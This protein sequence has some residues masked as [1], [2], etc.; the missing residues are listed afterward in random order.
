MKMQKLKISRVLKSGS[1]DLG[2]MENSAKCET[3]FTKSSLTDNGSEVR[4]FMPIV[5]GSGSNLNIKT[6]KK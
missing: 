3:L 1:K 6:M 2:Q 5:K 4:I